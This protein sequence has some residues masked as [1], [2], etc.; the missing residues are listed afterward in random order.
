MPDP[1]HH[2]GDI[3]IQQVPCPR[4][5]GT[6]LEKVGGRAGLVATIACATCNGTV[7]IDRAAILG[8]RH[9]FLTGFG[10]MAAAFLT[11]CGLFQ[12]GLNPAY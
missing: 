9:W 12:T 10:L 11:L 5:R 6:G 7:R 3:V 1:E 4:C 2:E 8:E